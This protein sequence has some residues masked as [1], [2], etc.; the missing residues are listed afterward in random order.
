[1]CLVKE[2]WSFTTVELWFNDPLYNKVLGIT[3]NILQPGQSYS[4][5]DGTEP[6]Y[7][8]PLIYYKQISP[9][10]W[11]FVK[12]RFHSVVKK[13]INIWNNIYHTVAFYQVLENTLEIF[14]SGFMYWKSKKSKQKKGKWLFATSDFEV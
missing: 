1:M 6:R 2:L 8:E 3:N 7:N 11:H 5:M 9:V 13:Q 4:K 12:L 14:W 10:S